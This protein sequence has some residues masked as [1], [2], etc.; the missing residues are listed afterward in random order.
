[1]KLIK[2]ISFSKEIEIDLRSRMITSTSGRSTFLWK[3]KSVIDKIDKDDY[4]YLEIFIS[5]ALLQLEKN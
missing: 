2:K 1:M 3:R 5:L 4:K